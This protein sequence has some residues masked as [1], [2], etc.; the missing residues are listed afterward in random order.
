MLQIK[1]MDALKEKMEFYLKEYNSLCKKPMSMVMFWFA[2]EHISR[3]VRILE[4][5]N[6]NVLLI[7]IGGSGRQS[8]VKLAAHIADY[9]VFQVC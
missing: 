5:D 8:I 2:I 1:D 4:Q 6:G 7:G 3:V 9:S